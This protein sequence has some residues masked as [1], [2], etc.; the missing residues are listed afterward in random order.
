MCS[1]KF[2]MM[3]KSKTVTSKIL[4]TDLHMNSTRTMTKL[5]SPQ[6]ARP[7]RLIRSIRRKLQNIVKY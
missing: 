3:I 2:C 5:S 4:N 6:H 1:L 7:A